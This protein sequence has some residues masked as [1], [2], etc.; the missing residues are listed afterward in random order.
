MVSSYCLLFL[1]SRIFLCFLCGTRITPADVGAPS[2]HS[3][4][5]SN[6][7]PTTLS[8]RRSPV[9]SSAQESRQNTL[10]YTIERRGASRDRNQ[11]TVPSIYPTS[12]TRS[13]LSPAAGTYAQRLYASAVPK[14]KSPSHQTQNVARVDGLAAPPRSADHHVVNQ[15]AH[16]DLGITH[17]EQHLD[18]LSRDFDSK[19]FLISS[20]SSPAGDEEW[21]RLPGNSDEKRL[22]PSYTTT[23]T[24]S[25]TQANAHDHVVPDLGDETP[26]YEAPA[27]SSAVTAGGPSEV[28]QGSST[29]ADYSDVIQPSVSPVLNTAS[30]LDSLPPDPEDIA[31][32]VPPYTLV[33][34]TP[35]PPDLGD[36]DTGARESNAP[37]HAAAVEDPPPAAP[38]Y[39]P[40]DS[41]LVNLPDHGQR[42]RSPVS[43]TTSGI[44][45]RVHEARSGPNYNEISCRLPT[46]SSHSAS[47][48][49]SDFAADLYAHPYGR[50][51]MRD[52]ARSTTTQVNSILAPPLTATDEMMTMHHGAGVARI[53]PISAQVTPPQQQLPSNNMSTNHFSMQ[54]PG[55]GSSWSHHPLSDSSTMQA[56]PINTAGMLRGPPGESTVQLFPPH[57]SPSSPSSSPV[58]FHPVPPHPLYPAPQ[59]LPRK[60]RRPPP[61]PNRLRR[62]STT[63]SSHVGTAHGLQM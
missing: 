55:D 17:A 19:A 21:N 24:P 42:T 23:F 46:I 49:N 61:V 22:V 32:E 30:S 33:D 15:R 60:L 3:S 39:T 62:P 56:Y 45:W 34:E 36:T 57:S 11:L 63:P 40:A 31:E 1:F 51:S 18:A 54:S 9:L 25:A 58:P 29:P 14:S 10:V 27:S 2:G 44:T 53:P 37:L 13:S 26:R 59:Q 20:A 52:R 8:S 7:G 50:H 12:Q 16:T 47:T 28:P 5:I 38:S 48:S 35:P 4:L 43:S 6:P 41:V